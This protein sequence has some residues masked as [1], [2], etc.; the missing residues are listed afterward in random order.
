M[1]IKIPS[2][3]V[4]KIL[5]HEMQ[6]ENGLWPPWDEE[7]LSDECARLPIQVGFSF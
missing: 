4:H 7:R 2:A 6:Q 5:Q 1:R 3:Y